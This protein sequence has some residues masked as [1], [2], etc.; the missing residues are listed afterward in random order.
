[1]RI[2]RT[3]LQSLTEND[4]HQKN[5]VPQQQVDHENTVQQPF[6]IVQDSI[7]QD[8]NPN[9]KSLFVDGTSLDFNYWN[10]YVWTIIRKMHL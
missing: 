8:P 10:S 7:P 5:I 6:G 2:L 9:L 4:D 3:I 1:M